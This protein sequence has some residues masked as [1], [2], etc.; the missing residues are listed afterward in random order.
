VTKLDPHRKILVTGAA[1]FI[2]ARLVEY[3]H[4]HGFHLVSV[5]GL[6]Y[7]HSRPEHVGLLFGEKVD[8]ELLPDW[9][10]KHGSSL[11][12]IYH[13]GAC[14]DTMQTDWEYLKKYNLE[15]SQ[16]I[17][18][19]A[20]RE[21]I[22]LVYASSAATY[23][24]G[25]CGYDDREEENSKLVPL[26]L[27]GESKRLFDLWVLQEEAKGNAP[28]L[29]SGF[30]FFNVYGFGERHKE[31]MASV[32]L[33]AFDQIQAT[34]EVKLFKSHRA[35]IANG[36]QKRDFIFVEDVIKVLHF[37]LTHPLRRGIFNL[38]TGKARS[39]L[40]LAK[41]VFHTLKKP[42]KIHFIDTPPEIREKYQYFTEARMLKLK[43]AGFKGSFVSL[44]DG[45]KSYIQR[46][47][48]A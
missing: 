33:H 26:N 10:E 5:D 30:K 22:P 40:D 35:G 16:M 1:G 23:G 15:Y 43:E 12:A 42:E 19:F 9:L 7:F 11:Q 2:G 18:N 45:V 28:P 21:K 39:F 29:W 47:L 38:G 3:F 36:E 31:R 13:L 8:I 25:S 46:L 41:A 14:S 24:D 27:Y 32:V 4:H 48:K 20:S 6:E 37:A 34:G 17:W 44:E